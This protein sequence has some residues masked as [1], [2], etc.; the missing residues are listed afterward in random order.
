MSAFLLAEE[1]QLPRLYSKGFKDRTPVDE[2]PLRQIPVH[3]LLI[4]WGRWAG[5][6][7][8]RMGLL[9]IEGRYTKGDTPPATAPL[10]ADLLLID[11]ECAVLRMQKAHRDTLRMLYVYRWSPCSICGALRPRLRYEAWPEWALDCRAMV[12]NL[13]KREGISFLA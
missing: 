10:S 12:V 2:I 6:R 7:A 1:E 13:L 11:V 9:S 4:K 5:Q 8:K 3:E